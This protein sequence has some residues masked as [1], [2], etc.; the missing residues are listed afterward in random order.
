MYNPTSE[1]IHN[2]TRSV[3][4]KITS[5]VE[6]MTFLSNIWATQSIYSYAQLLLSIA[7]T[8]YATAVYK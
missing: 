3:S 8:M 4:L 5:A 7:V 6:M 1:S 2:E